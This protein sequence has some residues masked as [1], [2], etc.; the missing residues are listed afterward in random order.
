MVCVV[1]MYVWFLNFDCL[2]MKYFVSD[3]ECNLQSNK[4]SLFKVVKEEESTICPKWSGIT[5]K[6]EILKKYTKLSLSV[7][8][9]TKCTRYIP[10]ITILMPSAPDKK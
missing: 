6:A 5:Q 8:N 9:L 1:W 4:I 3:T 2:E 10:L 7:V